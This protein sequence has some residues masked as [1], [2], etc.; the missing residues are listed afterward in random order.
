MEGSDDN[1]FPGF[2][3]LVPEQDE[4]A[5]KIRRPLSRLQ[6][7]APRPL[8]LKPASASS[9]QCNGT[10]VKSTAYNANASAFSSSASTSSSFTSCYHS[11]D[12]IPLLS[13]LV[14]PSLLEP[15]YVQGENVAKSHSFS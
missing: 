9:M 4:C 13:P 15:G 14:L 11:K 5:V 3:I 6:R 2:Q 12:P 10:A 1:E 7:R 8:Q